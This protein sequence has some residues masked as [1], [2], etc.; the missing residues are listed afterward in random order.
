MRAGSTAI[1]LL[2]ALAALPTTADSAALVPAENRAK[3]EQG[4]PY[5]HQRETASLLTGDGMLAHF[6]EF[7]IAEAGLAST[8]VAVAPAGGRLWSARVEGETA[9]PL[10]RDGKL[11]LRLPPRP[12]GKM[13]LYARVKLV[14]LELV[15]LE[16]GAPPWRDRHLLALPEPEMPVLRHRWRLLLPEG[17]VYQVAGSNLRPKSGDRL[18]APVLETRPPE[19]ARGDSQ[20][21]GTIVDPVGNA[22]PGVTLRLE[23]PAGELRASADGTGRFLFGRL[24]AGDYRLTADLEDFV[25]AERK[26]SLGQKEGRQ[27][28]FQ[29][30]LK[31]A[32]RGTVT[33]TNC[34]F[35][36]FEDPEAL[37]RRVPQCDAH[38][39]AAVREKCLGAGRFDL[40]REELASWPDGD[41]PRLPF[42]LPRRGQ[43]LELSGVT[44]PAR[45]VAEIEV[46]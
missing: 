33:E 19:K 43:A 45:V 34:Y 5:V 31:P 14:W 36:D 44:P 24:P 37:L 25:K 10:L 13:P 28:D 38:C 9:A 32:A 20:L 21:R 6:D 23:M 27:V 16:G 40:Y 3:V 1:F 18:D 42:E 4:R 39:G 12:A 11:E 46:Y 29:L 22:L 8:F 35:L 41:A 17:N 2:M 7:L 15:W 30:E 26:L